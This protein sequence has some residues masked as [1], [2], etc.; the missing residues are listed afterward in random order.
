LKEAAGILRIAPTELPARVA[1]LVEDRKRLEREIADL[2]KKLATGSGGGTADSPPAA[3]FNMA[4]NSFCALG[5]GG[6]PSSTTST[7][8]MGRPS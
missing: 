1:G 8:E 4:L 7:A 6:V 2:R 3:T 5:S